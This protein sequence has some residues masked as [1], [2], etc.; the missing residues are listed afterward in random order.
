MNS[1]HFARSSLRF[2]RTASEAFRDA[3]YGCA[4]EKPI[5]KSRPLVRWA[6]W[7]SFAGLCLVTIAGGVR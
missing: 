5:R 7:I 2:P 6:A 3:S 1:R 4:V